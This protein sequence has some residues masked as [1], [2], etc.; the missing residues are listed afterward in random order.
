MFWAQV[1]LAVLLALWVASHCY[2]AGKREEPL[3][4]AVLAVID[5]A[6]GAVLYF[7]GAFSLLLP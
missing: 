2:E 6:V 7:A 4:L 5:G 1:A 3:A